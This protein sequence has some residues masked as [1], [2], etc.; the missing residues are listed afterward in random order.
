MSH[1]RKET[2]YITAKHDMAQDNIYRDF[3]TDD[4]LYF[5]PEL[6]SLPYLELKESGKFATITQR[7]FPTQLPDLISQLSTVHDT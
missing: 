1:Y 2:S 4:R 3:Y 6:S 7:Q 5:Q